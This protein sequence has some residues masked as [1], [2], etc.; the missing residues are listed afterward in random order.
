MAVP[1]LDSVVS[2]LRQ[3]APGGGAGDD[4]LL[5]ARFRAGDEQALA[6]LVCRYA[7]LVWSVCRRSLAQTADAEDAFQATFLILTQQARSLRRGP[8]GPWLHVVASRTAAK[9]RARALRLA[10]RETSA[11][12][13]PAVSDPTADDTRGLL[14]EEVGRLPE[15][16]RLPVILCYLEGLTNEQAA[17]R[18]G[19]P[20]G[21]VLSRLSRARERLRQRLARRGL[22][23]SAALPAVAPAVPSKLLEAVTSA[24]SDRVL[25]AS[26][27]SLAEGV[28]LSMSMNKLKAFVLVL[29][30][31]ALVGGAGLWAARPGPAPEAR[32]AAKLNEQA[33]KA[34]QKQPDAK[35]RRENAKEQREN[36]RDDK[37]PER[38]AADF[39]VAL[40]RKIN[41]KGIDDPKLSLV[42][43][44]GSLSEQ[45]DLQ[46]D[47]NETAFA[48]EE[49][50][51]DGKPITETT[52]IGSLP[53]MKTT[54]RKVLTKVLSRLPAQSGATFVIRKDHVEIT[55][56][57]AVRR[58]LGL[59]A[60]KHDESSRPL[61]PMV[62]LVWQEFNKQQLD[63]ALRK[64]A[65]E[66]DANVVID[67]RVEEKASLHNVSLETALKVLT[68]A[69]GLAVV[70]IENVYYV[71]SPE[72]AAKLA[73]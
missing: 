14:D 45:Y 25:S 60:R 26:V 49:L 7:G 1:G 15:K 34:E 3:V 68:N 22:D 69:A 66:L 36:A 24:A 37:Q 73:K 54:L 21:T 44:L 27:V 32:R 18:L 31:A 41:F 70:K 56:D 43:L 59:P 39:H 30:A 51:Q 5:L 72:N 17:E 63:V 48:E 16:Y 10:S 12:V 50:Q 42:E 23:L 65:D 28:T 4:E 2:Y 71:T 64:I 9:A 11:A 62:Q 57:N 6:A 55:T 38:A 52:L 8:L 13:E 46:F 40:N 20:K 35:E 53:P 47:F 67:L 58:E 29:L 61:E 33:E 19:C